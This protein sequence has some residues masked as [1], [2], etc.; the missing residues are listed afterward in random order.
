MADEIFEEEDIF[1]LTD[2]DG[3]EQQFQLLGSCELEGVEYLALVPL[4]EDSEEY[5]ILK[6]ETDEDGEDILVTI[7]D[8]DEFDRVADI[9]EDELF[10]EIDYDGA[11]EK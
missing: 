6:R 2:E 7:D 3:T 10:G 8:D 11:E 4:D 1:T 5:V 9:F